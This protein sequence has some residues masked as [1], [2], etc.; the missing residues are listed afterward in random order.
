MDRFKS[1]TFCNDFVFAG[2]T[3]SESR[4]PLTP[5]KRGRMADADTLLQGFSPSYS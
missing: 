2:K 5:P 1:K 4:P 3:L